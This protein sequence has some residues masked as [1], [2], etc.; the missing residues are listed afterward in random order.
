MRRLLENATVVLPDRAQPAFSVLIEDGSIAAVARRDQLGAQVVDERADLGGDFLAPG[1]IDLHIHGTG[2]H[3]VDDG[4]EALAGLCALLP[5]YGVTGFL[6]TVAPRRPGEDAD[7][8]L[9]LSSLR[10]AGTRILGFHLEGPFL[11]L[12]GALPK[13]ALGEA[14]PRRVERLVEACR[15]YRA[16]FSVSPDFAGILGLLPIMAA[17]RTPV[18]MTHTSATV[19]QTTAAIEAGVR[20][21]THFY[22]VFPAP[23]EVEPGVRPCGAV[24][25]VLADPR[26]SVDFILD[27]EHV[28]PIACRMAL[29]CKGI[30]GVALIT[31]ANVGAGLPPGRVYRFAD[32]GVT[33]AYAGGP[34]RMMEDGPL[35]GALAG[36]GLTLDAALRNAIRML[37]LDLPR[38]VAMISSTPARI[39]GLAESKGRI[40][41][42]FDADLVQLDRDLRVR[43]TWIA[44]RPQF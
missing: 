16:I 5:K 37:G 12:T 18:F 8:L 7:F 44:G 41:P 9:T 15:P 14:D 27:G 3:L 33:F 40:A 11:T 24:E 43:Q 17:D 2:F 32:Y 25:A 34:A 29:A 20:H 4:P 22:D 6:P 39:V 36:S 21:A 42:D 10:P 13:E 19:D 30:E 35:P 28:A 23:P 1:F 31:D 38:A 26:V